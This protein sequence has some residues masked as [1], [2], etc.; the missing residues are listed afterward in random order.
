[1]TEQTLSVS[2]Y[3]RK[4]QGTANARRA[5][6]QGQVPAIMY[7]H[8]KQNQPMYVIEKELKKAMEN[9]S[10]KNHIIQLSLDNKVHQVLLKEVQRHPV[11]GRFLHL[12]FQRTQSIFFH[13]KL[14]YLSIYVFF[15][16]VYKKTYLIENLVGL[17]E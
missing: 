15:Q 11:N 8:G 14:I 9:P 2:A 3:A 6:H 4:E 17:L 16:F 7:G 1:M 12:D 10:F 5:R 13:S